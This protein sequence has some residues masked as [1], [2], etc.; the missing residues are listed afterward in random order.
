MRWGAAA[1]ERAQAVLGRALRPMS[2]HRGSAAYRL[3]L[4]QSLF[5]KFHWE[6]QAGVAA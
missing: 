6:Q 2:D 4:A 3:A 1:V 5:A